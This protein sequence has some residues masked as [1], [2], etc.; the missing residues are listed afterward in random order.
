MPCLSDDKPEGTYRKVEPVPGF[1]VKGRDN[2]FGAMTNVQPMDDNI[3]HLQC[4]CHILS[5]VAARLGPLLIIWAI[6]AA[7]D[8][9]SAMVSFSSKTSDGTSGSLTSKRSI[10]AIMS[11]E[12]VLKFLLGLKSFVRVKCSILKIIDFNQS[13]DAILNKSSSI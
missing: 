10:R 5:R 9:E 1:V 8:I 11:L 13:H 3:S 4:G 12:A 6:S 2:R 7:E